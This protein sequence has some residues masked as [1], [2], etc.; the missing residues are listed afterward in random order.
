[1]PTVTRTNIRVRVF[2]AGATGAPK[3]KVLWTSANKST[4]Y[5]RLWPYDMA[6]DWVEQVERSLHR[7][8]GYDIRI[9]ET[10]DKN[11]WEV[12]VETEE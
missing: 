3:I 10:F 2:I 5:T 9:T 4:Y 7:T 11:I 6:A 1:M 8:F 12:V